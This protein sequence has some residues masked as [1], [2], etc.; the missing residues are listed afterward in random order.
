MKS[1]TTEVAASRL[2]SIDGRSVIL[3]DTP[4]FDNT[5]GKDLHDILTDI[6][7]HLDTK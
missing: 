3:I 4:G 5:Q 1:C 2:I 7:D 6:A